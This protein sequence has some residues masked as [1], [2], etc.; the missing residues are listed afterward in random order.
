M[1]RS[2]SSTHTNGKQGGKDE[3]K[4]PHFK[5][6]YIAG[7]LAAGLIM[8]AA[9]L[10]AAYFSASGSGTGAAKVG[11]ASALRIRQ[12]GAGYNSLLDLTSPDTYTASQCL[13]P[14]TVKKEIGDT[15]TLVAATTKYTNLYGHVTSVTVA[16]VNFGAS[17]AVTVTLTLYSSPN[18]ASYTFT[19]SATITAGSPTNQVVTNVTFTLAATEVF[20]EK[21]FQYGISLANST[22][23][24]VA[25]A[26]YPDE[27][28]VGSSPAN[29]VWAVK[30][31]QTNHTFG[32]FEATASAT[33]GFIPAV[34]INV[35]NGV[36]PPLYPG[37]PA[38]SV[39]YAITN[40]N[41]GKIHVN[42]ITTAIKVSG[43]TITGAPSCLSA[44]FTLNNNP[45][46]YNATVA[47]GTKIVSNGTTTIQMNTGGTQ[48]AC[49]GKS[50]P[51]TFS[52]N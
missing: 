32:P 37:A 38:Q 51:L 42:S 12:V 4:L 21:T 1:A 17:K 29:T 48:N 31:T 13:Y 16:L 27:L 40:P 20:V 24:N 39:Q 33:T 23:V 34:Q 15:V 14:C 50:V 8:G 19:K 30:Y 7:A 44:W 45:F 2:T 41:P 46:G 22:G 5:K 52:S 36:V 25:L 11:S 43:S 18:V 10:A 9:G 26:H 3:V 6:K 35:V 47:P 28:T 49:V